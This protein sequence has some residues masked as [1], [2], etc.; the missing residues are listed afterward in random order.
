MKVTIHQP[1]FVPWYPFFQK[2]Q[3]V[4]KFIF[5]THCQY[6]KNGYQ[7]RF[8]ID[9]RWYTMSAKR[10]LVPIN[11]KIY[12]QP[13]KDWNKIKKSLPQYGRILNLFD[14]HVSGDLCLMN[15]GIIKEIVNLLKIDTELVVDQATDLK[16]T[17]RL[18]DLCV[19]NGAAEYVSGVS[20]ANYLELHK[21]SEAGVKVSFQDEENMIYKPV[22]EML[23]S[24]ENFC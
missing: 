15:M 17:D 4:D 13:E 24:N 19:K 14:K 2:V 21:F 20:G 18:V 7:N 3:A 5:L 1:A 9:D 10:G 8:N 12:L 22:L 23:R 11:Q 6:E 16:G